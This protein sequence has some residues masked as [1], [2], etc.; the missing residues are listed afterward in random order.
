MSVTFYWQCKTKTTWY[1]TVLYNI[2]V[3]VKPGQHSSVKT[4]MKTH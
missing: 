4:N 2:M 1:L 3:G